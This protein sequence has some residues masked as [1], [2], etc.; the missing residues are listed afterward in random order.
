MKEKSRTREK[1]KIVIDQVQI[2]HIEYF[3]KFNINEDRYSLRLKIVRFV[4]LSYI[5]AVYFY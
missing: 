5:N 3:L 1:K 2:E 4:V